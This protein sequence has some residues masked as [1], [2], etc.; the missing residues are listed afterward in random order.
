[1]STAQVGWPPYYYVQQPV[2]PTYL[3]SN[4]LYPYYYTN[5]YNSANQRYA[6]PTN[7]AANLYSANQYNANQ[8]QQQQQRY[9]TMNS[10]NQARNLPPWCYQRL[11]PQS[12]NYGYRTCK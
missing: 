9:T 4:Q 8:Q 6:Q 2:K 11:F 3:A 12:I 1:M 7:T 10:Y 5:N